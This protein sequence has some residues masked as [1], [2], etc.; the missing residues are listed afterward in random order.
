MLTSKLNHKL[1]F[2]FINTSRS[3]SSVSVQI[4]ACCCISLSVWKAEWMMI[5]LLGFHFFEVY[6]HSTTTLQS[7]RLY[8]I[9]LIFIGVKKN[10]KIPETSYQTSHL[11]QNICIFVYSY[12]VLRNFQG[13][14]LS[15]A[16]GTI[17][18]VLNFKNISQ[19]KINDNTVSWI[20][21][22]FWR[23]LS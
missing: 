5:L 11:V 15:H 3:T 21:F 17:E 9:F 2:I 20:S 7:E 12:N 16:Y 23:L 22:F 13:Y 19:S 6:Y 8:S 1:K 18:F 10:Q 4:P 14:I